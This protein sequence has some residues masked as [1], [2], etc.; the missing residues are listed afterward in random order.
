MHLQ[1]CAPP[2]SAA[3]WAGLKAE[4]DDGL[5]SQLVSYSATIGEC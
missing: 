1:F 2:D 5:L 4:P 3:I